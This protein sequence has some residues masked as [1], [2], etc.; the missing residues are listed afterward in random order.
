MTTMRKLP[1]VKH[2]TDV[3]FCGFGDGAPN[4][5]PQGHASGGTVITAFGEEVLTGEATEMNYITGRS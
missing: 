5:G 1:S 4:N 3:V 2:W